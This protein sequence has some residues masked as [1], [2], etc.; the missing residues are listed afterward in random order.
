MIL[1]TTQNFL[2]DVGGTQLYVTGLADAL[3]ARGHE[4]EVYCDTASRGAARGVDQARNYPIHRFGGPRPWMRWRKARAVIGRLA[5]QIGRSRVRAVVTDTWKSLELI[6]AESLLHARVFCL[7]HGSEFLIK[8]GS[9]KERRL[10]SALAKANIVAANSRFTASLAQPFAPGG[11]EVRVIL[12]GIVP[13]SGAPRALP[14]RADDGTIRIL[15][16]ARLEPRKGVDT[17]LASLPAL[18]EKIPGI[19]YDVIGKGED[20]ARLQQMT[21]QLGLSG[22]VTFHGYIPDEKKAALISGATLFALP[23]RREPGSV[24]GFGI[25]FLEAA[26]YGVPSLAGGD[27]GTADAVV[28]GE[29]GR[30]VDGDDAA[31]V[32]QT[33]LTMLTDREACARLG[34]AAHER[35]WTTFAWDAAVTRFEQALRL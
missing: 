29:T 7:A 26:A 18:R 15:T 21:Q 4:V 3:A 24:E 25:V 16:I 23:N 14:P 31:A 1:F 13:P 6:P 10:R 32:Q 28:D 30:M 33:L 27:G 8:P 17:V 34:D 20:A 9:R 2:P 11:T 35:F 19:H 22:T 5:D 12:P